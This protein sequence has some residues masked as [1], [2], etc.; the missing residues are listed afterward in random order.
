MQMK[1]SVQG[2]NLNNAKNT[3]AEGMKTVLWKAMIK[4]EEIAKLKAPVDTGNLKNRIHLNPLQQGAT[5]Y[6]L[7]DGVEYGVYVEY[8]TKP[9]YVPLTPLLGWAGRVLKDKNAAFAV[10]AKIS[11]VGTSAQPFFRPAL[12]E[13]QQVWLPIIKNEVFGKQ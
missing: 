1:F 11:K 7:S 8:G 3:T 13:V 6:T 9:H 12:H 2:P 5:E 4:M 10:R